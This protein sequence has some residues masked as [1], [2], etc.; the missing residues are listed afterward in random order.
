MLKL[1]TAL[2]LAVSCLTAWVCLEGPPEECAPAAIDSAIKG[3]LEESHPVPRAPTGRSE[4]R[5]RATDRESERADGGCAKSAS[6]RCLEADLEDLFDRLDLAST[7]CLSEHPNFQEL[8]RLALEVADVSRVVPESIAVDE[9]GTVAGRLET[10]SSRVAGCFSISGNRYL[11]QFD[12]SPDCGDDLF[13]KRQ[14]SFGFEE[15]LHEPSRALM[16]V[17]YHPDTSKRAPEQESLVGWTL[18]FDSRGATAMPL[19][20]RP[21]PAGRGWLIG[22]AARFD[23]IPDIATYPTAHDTWLAKLEPYA[24]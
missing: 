3:S 12:S 16:T 23:S 7:T 4:A 19:S 21:G 14:L 8:A 13:L 5:R 24:E 22:H 9:D 20:M 10:G 1:V 17:Q 6:A 2:T 11:V 18:N 15:R